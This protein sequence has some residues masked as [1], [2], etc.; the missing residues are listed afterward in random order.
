MGIS[1]GTQ[2]SSEVV[3]TEAVERASWFS[4]G[5]QAVGHFFGNLW[6]GATDFVGGL[7]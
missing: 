6:N 5:L 4:L 3:T 7:F 2:K 1:H